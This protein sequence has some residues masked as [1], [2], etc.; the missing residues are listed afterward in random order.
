MLS[1]LEREP[2]GSVTVHAPSIPFLFST[3]L[4]TLLLTFAYHRYSS[5]LLLCLSTS[6][7]HRARTLSLSVQLLSLRRRSNQLNSPSTFAEYAK[8]Q[9]QMAQ[10][11]KELEQA[12]ATESAAMSGTAQTAALYAPAMLLTAVAVAAGWRLP[13]VTIAAPHWL[14]YTPLRV[15]EQH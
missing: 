2:L 6:P 10:L 15:S 8:V 13:L 12:K 3:L 4:I 9:R 14:A 1:A 7:S 5:H 11:T